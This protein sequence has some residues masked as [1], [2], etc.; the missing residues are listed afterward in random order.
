MGRVLKLMGAGTGKESSISLLL[1][2]SVFLG[3]FLGAFDVTAHSLFLSVL[4]EKMMARAYVLSGFAGILLTALHAKLETKMKFH[5]LSLLSLAFITVVTTLLWALLTGHGGQWVIWLLFLSFGPV[6]ILAV[7]DFRGAVNRFGGPHPDKR[8][9]RATETG[10]IA[11]I[12]LISFSIAVSISLNLKVHNILLA[13]A[14]SIMLVFAIRAI[15]ITRF[16]QPPDNSSPGAGA[17]R[18]THSVITS[19]KKDSFVRKLVFFTGL[20]V[21][22]VFFIQYSFMAG[23]RTH[24]P[25]ATGMARFLGMFTTGMML[26]VIMFRFIIFPFLI[27]R[28]GLRFCLLI[29]PVLIA[30][31]AIVSAIVGIISGHSPGA[32]TGY[33]LFFMMLTLT[34]LFSGSLR[35]SVDSASLKVIFRPLGEKT[36]SFFATTVNEA[37]VLFSGIVLTGLGMISFISIIHFPVVLILISSLWLIAAISLSSEF[38]NLLLKDVNKENEEAI[39]KADLGTIPVHDNRFSAILEIKNDYFNILSGHLECLKKRTDQYYK[40]ILETAENENDITLIPALK[41]ISSDTELGEAVRQ[42]SA[43][44]A[45]SLELYGSDLIPEDDKLFEARQILSGSRVPQ[46]TMILRMLRDRS[47]SSKRAAIFMIG[48]F[49]MKE[50]INEVCQCL[51][52]PVLEFEAVKVLR[53]FGSDADKELHRFSLLSSGNNRISITILRLL[54]EN[55]TSENMGFLFARLLSASRTIKE[56][57]L[58]KLALSGFIPSEE[59]KSKINQLISDAIGTMVWNLSARISIKRQND[60][61]LTETFDKEISRL[62]SFLFDLFSLAYNRSAMRKI[63]ACLDDGSA[64]SK[65]FAVEMTGLFFDEPLRSKVISL[66]EE[67][68][69]EDKVRQLSRFYPVEIPGYEKLM[70][71]IINRDYNL[72]GICVRACMLRNMNKIASDSFGESVVA[73]LFNPEI[74]LQEEAAGLLARAGKELYENA[75]SRIPHGARERTGMIVSGDAVKESLV[76]EKANFLA[77]RFRG[78]VEEDLLSL[79]GSLSFTEKSMKRTLPGKGG[80]ILWECTSDNS[81]IIYEQ[82]IINELTYVLPLSA[83]EDY[84]FHYP[85]KAGIILDYIAKIRS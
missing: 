52:V 31:F 12:I 17:E 71:E 1:I 66:L 36:R 51:F 11:G 56:I 27:R 9:S 64:E 40:V 37:A 65:G 28:N 30:L 57:A 2:Q 41:K 83:V 63:K 16:L 34:R 70:E 20:S 7:Q 33:A 26:M 50:M 59:E 84:C 13:G 48:K 85:E 55:V 32:L 79:A 72:L 82:D 81:R 10:I 75:S 54:A 76:L 46:T 22:A 15:T 29:S 47:A 77:S 53:S 35:E 44:V 60:V 49:R 14:V 39:V 62:N 67:S 21:M 3:I 45:E 38:R 42:R 74:I 18:D 61:L 69:D 43:K 8:T 80:Y 4:D 73:L 58:G 25:S 68:T 19:L 78:L 23:T 6:N 5:S 24:Y